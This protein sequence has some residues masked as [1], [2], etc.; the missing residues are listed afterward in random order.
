MRTRGPALPAG[1]RHLAVSAAQGPPGGAA[2]LQL[3]LGRRLR[4]GDLCLSFRHKVTGLHSGALQVFVRKLGA[5]GAALW[6]RNGGHGWRQTHITLRGADV[7]S[8]S[9]PAREADRGGFPFRGELGRLPPKPPP[10]FL[11]SGT[12]RLPFPGVVTL[13]L[14]CFL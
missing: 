7:K 2:R 5:R 12:R 10:L 9:R 14:A 13:P 11:N 3:P 4:A 6:G 1:G 8:V